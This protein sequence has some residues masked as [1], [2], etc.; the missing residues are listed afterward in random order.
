MWYSCV[1]RYT[2]FYLSPG[3]PYIENN[4]ELYNT[5]LKGLPI[6]EIDSLNESGW[7]LV[8]NDWEKNLKSG[9]LEFQS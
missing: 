9:R 3:E 8:L 6:S 4:W 2:D 5:I 1:K 7:D